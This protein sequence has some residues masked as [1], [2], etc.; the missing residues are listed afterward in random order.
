[1]SSLCPTASGFFHTAEEISRTAQDL[2][3]IGCE[4]PVEPTLDASHSSQL[5]IL[6][7]LAESPECERGYMLSAFSREHQGGFQ[8]EI[9]FSWLLLFKGQHS[10]SWGSASSANGF[11]EHLWLDEAPA[12]GM[13]A[14]ARDDS[15]QT[16]IVVSERL[17]RAA[18][19][20][21]MAA[22]SLGPDARQYRDGG[23]R[24]RVSCP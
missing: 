20:S 17:L 4:F 22:R 13:R 8:K 11:Q 15:Q 12:P 14:Q 5:L 2:A 19:L 6:G 24:D 7:R 18:A 1:M 21:G 16:V 9:L 3:E 23:N 10:S